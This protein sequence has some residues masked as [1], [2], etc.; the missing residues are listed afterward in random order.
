MLF[1]NLTGAAHKEYIVDSLESLSAHL[2]DM[3]IGEDD[4]SGMKTQ[5]ALLN[6]MASEEN[7]ASEADTQTEPLDRFTPFSGLPLEL[8]LKIWKLCIRMVGP[9]VIKVTSRRGGGST[10]DNFNATSAALTINKEAHGYIMEELR[11]SVDLSKLLAS[12]VAHTIRCR[13]CDVLFLV[14]CKLTWGS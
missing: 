11:L 13:R 3:T 14:D 5:I 7:D 8:R 1:K 6:N 9:Q 4:A 2:N 12:P 10:R